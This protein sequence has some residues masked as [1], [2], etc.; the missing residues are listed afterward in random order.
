MKERVLEYDPRKRRLREDVENVC[1]WK[2]NLRLG[3][4]VVYKANR[5]RASFGKR[6]RP[7]LSNYGSSISRRSDSLSL[8]SFFLSLSVNVFESFDRYS[9]G[10]GHDECGVRFVLFY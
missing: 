9:R 10:F 2:H 8:F 6:G 7:R 4:I 5:E 1:K 3:L